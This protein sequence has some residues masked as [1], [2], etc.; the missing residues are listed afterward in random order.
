MTR[1]AGS[2]PAFF[3]YSSKIVVEIGLYFLER[4]VVIQALQNSLTAR[5]VR[6]SHHT[7]YDD[8][9]EIWIQGFDELHTVVRD[10]V[11][12][13]KDGYLI[14]DVRI[15]GRKICGGIGE[16]INVG[17]ACIAVA[18]INCN[19]NVVVGTCILCSREIGIRVNAVG[20]Q[21][22]ARN[23]VA[24]CGVRVNEA[25]GFALEISKG[26]DA[27]IGTSD[28]LSLIERFQLTAQI[29]VGVKIVG[30]IL[31]NGNQRGDYA[32]LLFC[33]Q[34]RE[35]VEETDLS[36][37]GAQRF[38]RCGEGSANFHLEGETRHL[39]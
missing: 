2:T 23:N 20:F 19:C 22:N 12:I 16:N 9:L 1:V 3:K 24:G 15:G 25:E 29:L 31:A 39:A 35:G 30:R 6:H 33:K 4:V 36:F 26:C 10:A 28:K 7:F 5:I 17:H 38:N 34:N 11:S 8:F 21:N 37:L 18:F 27:F 14:G 32:I 13:C